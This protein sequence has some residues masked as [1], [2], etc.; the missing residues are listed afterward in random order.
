MVILITL[1]RTDASRRLDE[2]EACCLV[3]KRELNIY[4][5]TSKLSKVVS[6]KMKGRSSK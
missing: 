4:I 6:R 2:E 5:M 3:T 1:K